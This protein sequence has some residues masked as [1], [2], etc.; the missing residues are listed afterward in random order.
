M[1]LAG[2]FLFTFSDTF[3]VGHIVQPQNAPNKSEPTTIRQVYAAG[4]D[5]N[6]PTFMNL[7]HLKSHRSVTASSQRFGSAA[8]RFCNLQLY[9]TSYA[10]RSALP[11]TAIGFF[12]CFLAENHGAL[13]ARYGFKLLDSSSGRWLVFSCCDV[14]DYRCWLEAFS[15]ERRVVT[16]DQRNGFH[17]TSLTQHNA[18]LQQFSKGKRFLLDLYI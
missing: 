17:V 5:V 13:P 8:I 2:N 1:F 12:V 18:Q 3:V 4:S 7:P 15:V 6:K 11:A 16:E 10:V 14:T 9:R